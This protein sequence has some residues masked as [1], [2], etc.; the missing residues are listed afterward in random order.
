MSRGDGGNK[1]GKARHSTKGIG[2]D[3]NLTRGRSLMERPPRQKQNI[4]THFQQNKIGSMVPSKELLEHRCVISDPSLTN[5]CKELACFSAAAHDALTL[6]LSDRHVLDAA[7]LLRTTCLHTPLN[8]E[9]FALA[10]F[11][12]LCERR[13]FFTRCL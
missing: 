7:P 9:N 5:K 11:C 10:T 8:L 4:Q 13:T 3:T 12:A 1:F 2:M 6:T